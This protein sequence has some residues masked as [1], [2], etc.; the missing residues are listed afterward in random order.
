MLCTIQRLLINTHLP[1][2]HI[3]KMYLF[4]LFDLVLKI[5]ESTLRKYN[6]PL[7]V[8]QSQGHN[9]LCHKL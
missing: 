6:I 1:V 8:Q 7:R 4:I 2:T 9:S 5:E 3:L